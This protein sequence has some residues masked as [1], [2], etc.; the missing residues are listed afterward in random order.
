METL[1]AHC[2]VH[3]CVSSELL[4]HCIWA[5]P[6]LIDVAKSPSKV[7]V[8]IYTPFSRV[9]VP[10]CPYVTLYYQIKKYLHEKNST[11]K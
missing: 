11:F 10:S 4:G 9:A 8:P 3:V 7:A 5:F 6:I 1:V 2:S